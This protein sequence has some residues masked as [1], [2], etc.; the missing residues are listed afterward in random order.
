MLGAALLILH[1]A[2]APQTYDGLVDAFDPISHWPLMGLTDRKGVSGITS[3][4]SHETGLPP[5]AQLD[6]SGSA[7][8]FNGSDAYGTILH[9]AAY[10]VSAGGVFVLMQPD[11][12]VTKMQVLNSGVGAAGSMALEVAANGQPRAY[13]Y[14]SDGTIV[15]VAGSAGQIVA[16][17]SYLYGV[18]WG[19]NGLRLWLMDEDL[20]PGLVASN[21]E[22]GWATVT[23]TA[24]KYLGRW[25]GSAIDHFDGVLGH[26]QFYGAELSLTQIETLARPQLVVW[27]DDIDAGSVD[28]DATAV[29]DLEPHAHPETGFTPSI[30]SQGSLGTA[31]VNA[32]DIDYDAGST[33][34]DGD[35]FTVKITAGGVDSRT[36][37]ITIDVEE[38]SGGIEEFT[39]LLRE[40]GTLQLPP[41][42][43][44]YRVN[45]ADDTRYDAR[46]ATWVRTLGPD[47]GSVAHLPIRVSGADGGCW[48]G[49][50]VWGD[51]DEAEPRNSTSNFGNSKAFT[52]GVDATLNNFL[53][54]GFRVHNFWDGLVLAFQN[55]TENVT[56][57]GSW[58]SHQRDDCI[59]NDNKREGLLVDDC[60]FDGAYMMFSCR[61][62]GGSD[63]SAFTWTIRATL[64][65]ME[66]MPGPDASPD[67]GHGFMFKL[68]ER[69][70]RFVLTDCIFAWEQGTS[71]QVSDDIPGVSNDP[72]YDLLRFNKLASATNCTICWLGA[73]SYPAGW[74]VPSGFTV[75]TGATAQNTWNDAVSVWKTGHP[76]VYRIPGVD[77]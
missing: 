49:G 72:L 46:N 23:D 35:T 2:S 11:Q 16:G 40:T 6:I 8:G 63:A 54:E 14:R 58:F 51:Q 29:V 67:P 31:S 64:A 39:C 34:G 37:T 4:G 7:R 70:V 68:N 10:Q 13:R 42:T 50:A 75:L 25:S 73:G 26:L 76:Q 22:T 74:W 3:F 60:L 65:R 55:N 24:T 30:V 53:I 59:E 15:V 45:H 36:A 48:S 62:S 18:T 17:T 77:D 43:N 57:R 28:E 32:E 47:G 56:L 38:V 20:Q 66:P 12:A 5:I 61:D 69:A 1:G 19:P 9:N 71:L 27:L 52:I 21:P 44:D 33:P 41:G